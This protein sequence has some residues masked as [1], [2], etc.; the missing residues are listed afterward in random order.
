MHR[1]ALTVAIL[2]VAGLFGGL[3]ILIF[4]SPDQAARVPPIPLGAADVVALGGAIYLQKR[5]TASVRTAKEP[6][7]MAAIGFALLVVIAIFLVGF[8]L[9]HP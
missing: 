9:T 4:G 7:T 8:F 2:A 6:S 3:G 5:R 1:A